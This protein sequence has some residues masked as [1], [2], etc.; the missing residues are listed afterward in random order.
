MLLVWCTIDIDGDI[1]E[2]RVALFVAVCAVVVGL[3]VMRR[4]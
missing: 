1:G 4:V 3:D 2:K